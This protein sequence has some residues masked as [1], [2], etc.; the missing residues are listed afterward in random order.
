MEN[1]FEESDYTFTVSNDDTETV[2]KVRERIKKSQECNIID[3]HMLKE[4][5]EI[6][7]PDGIR[8]IDYIGFNGCE[9]LKKITIPNSVARIGS[10]AFANCK[11]LTQINIPENV[12]SIGESAFSGCKNL[13]KVKIPNSFLQTIGAEN[14]HEELGLNPGVRISVYENELNSDRKGVFDKLNG[15]KNSAGIFD[16]IN[17]E[18]NEKE[19]PP[20]TKDSI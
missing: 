4:L 8:S 20:Q 5:T 15:E 6:T 1:Q 13:D 16:K 10:M 12:T 17:D 14:I 7:I 9:N 11:N 3:L 18:K 2:N 19:K